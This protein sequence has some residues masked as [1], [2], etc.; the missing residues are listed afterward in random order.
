MK[1]VEVGILELIHEKNRPLV[2]MV[3]ALKI[4]RHYLYGTKC[5][6]YTYHKSLKYLFTQKELN[7]R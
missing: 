4:G 6:I 2:I 5:E 1:W 7:M 3:F